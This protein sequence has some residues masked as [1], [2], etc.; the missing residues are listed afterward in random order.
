MKNKTK[1]IIFDFD[2]VLA[3]TFYTFYP[4][5]RDGMKRIG[6]KIS[7]DQ[8]RKLFIG[9]VHRG[10]KDFIND[11][12]KYVIFSKFRKDN[13]D[14]YYYDP[15]NKAMLYRGARQLIKKINKN[16]ILTIAS[17]GKEDN[18]KDL[19]KQNGIDEF[20]NLILANSSDT[21]EGVIKEILDKFDAKPEE[22]IMITDTVGDLRVAKKIGLKTAAVTWGFHSVRILKSEKPDYLASSFEMLYKNIK[23]F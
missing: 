15:N 22:T 23:A 21:K 8:Y 5:I 11:Y 3:D 19:L 12:S 6:L 13:Y 20:F 18:I 16:H 10:F 1:I 14:K 17:S 9:N 7:P 4:L 2:G